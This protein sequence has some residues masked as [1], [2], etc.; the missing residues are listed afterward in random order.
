MP[1]ALK[2]P[3]AKAAV[4]KYWEK[5]EKIPAW[6]PTKVRNEKEVI[7]EARNKGRKVHFA[8][9]MDL[10][11]LKNSEPQYQKYKGRVALGGDI[12]KD[13]AGSYAVLT[14]QGSSASQM[15]ASKVMDILSR[16]RDAQ[17]KQQTQYPFTSRSKW[18]MHHDC[19]KFRSQNVQIFGYVCQNTNCL[20]HSPV[21]KIQC[22]LLSETCTVILWQDCH[23][24]GNLRKFYQ[25]T[26]GRKFQIVNAYSCYREKALFLSVYVD[27]M[28][29]A[30]K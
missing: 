22:F 25:N 9:L 1:Q 7:D 15:T 18:K 8:A 29:L 5:L 20:N 26:N 2:I 17:D 21:W 30:G 28:K 3:D 14:E 13:D 23:G 11:H 4:E 12:V 6:Q 19:S 16:P 27:D 24:K 10:C